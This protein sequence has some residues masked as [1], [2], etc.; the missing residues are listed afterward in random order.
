ML[1]EHITFSMT[2]NPELRLTLFAPV[3]EAD[4]IT[5]F[6][7]LVESFASRGRDNGRAGTPA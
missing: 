4:S 2:D 3:A 7:R 6:R 1:A 5:R